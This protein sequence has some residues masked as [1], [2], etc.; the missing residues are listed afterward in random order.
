MATRTVLAAP[1]H[2]A[3]ALTRMAPAGNMI[4][5]GIASGHHLQRAVRGQGGECHASSRR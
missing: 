1:S 2:A 4:V 5:A 3:P